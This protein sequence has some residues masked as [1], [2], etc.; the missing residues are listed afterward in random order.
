MT[1]PPAARTLA[2][3][4][5]LAIVLRCLT[6]IYVDATHLPPAEDRSIA[7]SLLDGRG[8]SFSAFNHPGPT[9]IRPPVYPMLLA[10]IYATAG[11]DTPR[12][13]I[14]ALAINVLAGA[15]SVVLAYTIGLRVRAPCRVPRLGSPSRGTPDET[16]DKP[17]SHG[18]A[19]QAVAPGNQRLALM[20]AFGIAI[21]PTQLYAG[22]YV[23]GL[24]IA[25][26]L[27]LLAI[28]LALSKDI[29]LA[30]PA[31]VVA[32]LA[33]L[34]ESVLWLPLIGVVLV[35]A[36]RSLAFATLMLAGG[37]VV[38]SPWLYRN[39]IVHQ[40]ITGIT[41]ELWPDVFRGNGPEATGSIHLRTRT[42]AGKP[43]TRFDRLSP[44]EIDQLKRQ[45]DRVRNDLLRKWSIDWIRDNPLSYIKLCV[46]RVGK[47]L[48]LDWDHPKA[49][50]VLNVGSR[51]VLLLAM[52]AVA[53]T[54]ASPMRRLGMGDAGVAATLVVAIGLVVAAAF[55]LSEARNNVFMDFPQLVAL[56]WFADRKLG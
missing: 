35:L 27:M 5:L 54:P 22:A 29:R 2:A 7:I 47:T 16:K 45:P 14:V 46:V 28:R 38:V 52:I 44:I 11:T 18:L 50:N 39:A 24:S 37:L 40:Q 32:G 43:Q 33:A 19:Y 21:W 15:G 56:A 55:T 30:L 41:N 49:W 3:I 13:Q 4:V 6:L 8:F 34:T 1:R 26:L 53:A 9:S 20:L 23:Q 12:A 17:A 25:M 42:H 48:W 36:W 51:S 10:T 31:G